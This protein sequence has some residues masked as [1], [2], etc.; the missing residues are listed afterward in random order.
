[1]AFSQCS[2]SRKARTTVAVV[3]S[4]VMDVDAVASVA[5]DVA[6]VVVDSVVALAVAVLRPAASPRGSH[7]GGA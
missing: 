3:D 6:V 2:A 1:M 7:V 4:A 5:T